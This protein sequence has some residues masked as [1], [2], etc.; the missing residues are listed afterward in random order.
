MLHDDLGIETIFTPIR[1]LKHVQILSH[2]KDPIPVLKKCWV[3]YRIP[4]KDCDRSYV[5]QTLRSLDWRIKEHQRSVITGDC[6]SNAIA[7]HAWTAHHHIAWRDTTI[8]H[9]HQRWFQR[10]ILELW[11]IHQFPNLLN[12]DS[13]NL[14]KPYLQLMDFKTT[15]LQPPIYIAVRAMHYLKCHD[16]V[17]F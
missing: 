9:Q 5:W 16:N 1:S 4:C 14:P 2:P 7:E 3:V 11:Y 10:C 6:D 12:R 15:E 17:L 13:G 8:L